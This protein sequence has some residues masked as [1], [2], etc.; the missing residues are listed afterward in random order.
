VHRGCRRRNGLRQPFALLG[1]LRL[2]RSKS[3]KRKRSD[4]S[5][6]YPILEVTKGS[7]YCVHQSRRP[8]LSSQERPSLRCPSAASTRP[9]STA[10]LRGPPATDPDTPAGSAAHVIDDPLPS[11]T[12]RTYGLRSVPLTTI[13]TCRPPHREQTSRS[14]HRARAFRRRTECP[15]RRDRARP[16]DRIPDTRRSTGRGRR[17][18]CP[19]SSAGQGSHQIAQERR[20]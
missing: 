11:P 4:G 6:Y 12:P 3:T 17:Q 9:Y 5:G 19:A 20:R 13:S 8:L 2:H 14:R 10:A 7:V 15:S 18:C 16:D 1:S